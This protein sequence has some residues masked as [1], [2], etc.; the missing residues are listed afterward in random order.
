MF[1]PFLVKDVRGCEELVPLVTD[2]QECVRALS[3]VCIQAYQQL[4]GEARGRGRHYQHAQGHPGGMN[5]LLLIVCCMKLSWVS[6]YRI[7]F[8]LL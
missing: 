8:S 1:E 4:P 5:V 6:M 3:D 7:L 2:V